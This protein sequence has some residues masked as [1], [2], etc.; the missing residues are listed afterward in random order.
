MYNCLITIGP[1]GELLCRL[2]AK[3][4][5]AIYKYN[6]ICGQTVSVDPKDLI[7]QQSIIPIR[8]PGFVYR[9]YFDGNYDVLDTNIPTT[10]GWTRLKYIV[11]RSSFLEGFSFTYTK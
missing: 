5:F 11:I 4:G 7:A 3:Y 8:D 10:G 9:C 1:G 2:L 6:T